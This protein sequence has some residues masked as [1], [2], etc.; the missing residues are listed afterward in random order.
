MLASH[1]GGADPG[2]YNCEYLVDINTFELFRADDATA[3]LTEDEL[4]KYTSLVHEA[5][6]KELHQFIER[7]VF[8]GVD[9]SSLPSDCNVVDCAWIHII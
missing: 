5:V 3:N 7:K 9:T 1:F 8:V 6:H 4:A 2:P